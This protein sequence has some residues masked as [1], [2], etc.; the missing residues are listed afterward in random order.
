MWRLVIVFAI[1]CSITTVFSE[2][3]QRAFPGAEGFGAFA[4][5]GRGGAVYVVTTLS[6]YHP[7]AAARGAVKRVK[8]GEEI[9][10][11]RPA[12][13][14][15]RRIP[16]SLR[17]AVEATGPR[18]IVFALG[19]TIRLKAPLVI[20]HPFITIAGQS[21]PGGG[22]CIRDYGLVISNTHDVVIRYLRVRPGDLSRMSQ[23]AIC[24][25][26]V[27]N[28]IVDHCSASWG[29]DENLSVSGE[30]T[31]AATVQWCIISES[32]NDSWHPKGPHGMG[33]LIRT[34]GTVSY[35]HNLYV[36]NSNRNPRPGTYGEPPIRFDF[37]N[38]V[39]YNWGI[40]A[41]YTAE[42]PA[43]VNYIANYLKTGPELRTKPH[44]AFQI[45]G[46]STRMYAEG[47]VLVDGEAVLRDDWALIVRES[48]D[49]KLKQPFP[50]PATWTDRADK[51][52]ERVLAGAGAF[53]PERDAVDERLLADIKAGTGMVIDSQAQVG[54]WPVLEAGEA[55]QDTDADG[56]PDAWEQAHQLDPNAPE[57]QGADGDGD[58]Y[59]NLETYLNELAI[60]PTLG[61][62]PD[63]Q[64]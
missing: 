11:T 61:R 9:L 59:T 1:G 55:P 7:G 43:V 57:D 45:G 17:A 18:A 8:T 16:G 24:L 46:V 19:G 36:H 40:C 35:H 6:D 22:I 15:E 5:G 58:G 38:N 51:A 52:Y 29:V 21:A 3:A 13:E 44:I 41:G 64:L 39:I 56:M 54:G 50:V 33:S 37:R 14:R 48:E 4:K 28:V 12:I 53:L 31:T 49:T 25:A 42:D 20:A 26:N 2:E 63:A 32:L 23:D 27:Q 60:R 47:N 10:P 30:G 34:N 62:E